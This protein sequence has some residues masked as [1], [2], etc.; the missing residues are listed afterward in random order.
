M[1]L[2]PLRHDGNSAYA[3][4]KE[5]EVAGESERA[6]FYYGKLKNKQKQNKTKIGNGEG[7]RNG[8]RVEV[9]HDP[10]HTLAI[11]FTREPLGGTEL[12]NWGGGW[13]GYRVKVPSIPSW[14]KL[15]HS[16]TEQKWRKP[17]PTEV[18][19]G[20]RGEDSTG[21]SEEAWL[22][23]LGLWQVGAGG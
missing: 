6:P 16:N 1:G 7:R 21:P 8:K 2:F 10:P 9:P 14:G 5:R 4:S 22:V 20:G 15:R 18:T 19:A 23:N 17:Y 12:N 13:G 3:F 11:Q